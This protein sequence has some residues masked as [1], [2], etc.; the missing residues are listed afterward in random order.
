MGIFGRHWEMLQ[1]KNPTRWRSTC[2]LIILYLISPVCSFRAYSQD[3]EAR[4]YELKAAF[5]LNFAK[6]INWPDGSFAN[7]QAPFAICVVG[8]DPFGKALDAYFLGKTI[9]SHS[10]EIDRFPSLA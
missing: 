2:L 5:L 7:A 6:F 10:V 8:R 4:E 3:A 9:E 1:P